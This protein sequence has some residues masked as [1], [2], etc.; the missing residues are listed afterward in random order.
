MTHMSPDEPNGRADAEHLKPAATLQPTVSDR[1]K[2][3][4]LIGADRGRPR[5]RDPARASRLA[6]PQKPT[7]GLDLQ[8]GLEVV[9][10]GGSAEGPQAHRRRTSTARSRSC[11]D[12]I[13]K[14]GVSE[15][16]I[17]KQGTDQIVIQLAGVHDP[18]ARGEADRQDGAARCFFDFEA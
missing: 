5:R 18:A 2:Y 10:E 13:N 8:G 16:E 11:S 1:R 17:R 14:L 15:P 7:L 9:A 4:I 12:R 3:L 6:G